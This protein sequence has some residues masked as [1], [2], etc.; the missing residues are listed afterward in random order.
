MY[1]IAFTILML[2]TVPSS[3]QERD[4]FREIMRELQSPPHASAFQMEL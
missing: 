4:Q 2:S 3:G 1:Y